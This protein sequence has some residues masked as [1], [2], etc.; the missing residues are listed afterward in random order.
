VAVLSCLRLLLFCE[1]DAG[2]RGGAVGEWVGLCVIGVGGVVGVG[3]WC[4][5]FT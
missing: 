4:G 3:G 2:G 5:L 1:W